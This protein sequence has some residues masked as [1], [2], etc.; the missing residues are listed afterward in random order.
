MNRDVVRVLLTEICV[1]ENANAKAAKAKRD[2]EYDCS[3]GKEK[4]ILNPNTNPVWT[5]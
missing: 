5:A 3:I 2:L 4:R 1:P